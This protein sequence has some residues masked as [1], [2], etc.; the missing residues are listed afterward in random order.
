MD[1]QELLVRVRRV[2]PGA[3]YVRVYHDQDRIVIEEP[4]GITFEKLAA[5]AA[6]FETR[7]INVNCD[8]GCGSDPGHDTTISIGG[9]KVEAED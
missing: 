2:V 9:V 5:L 8:L 7:D 6:E 4:G 3:S 1:E